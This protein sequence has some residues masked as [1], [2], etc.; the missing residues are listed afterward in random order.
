MNKV[1][2]QLFKKYKTA[3]SY[4]DAALPQLERDIFSTG[5]Y[6]TKARR[7]KALGQMLVREYGGKVPS[8]LNELL[9]LPGVG[10]KTAYL[11]LKKAF[12][13][14]VGI[15]VDT[16]VFRLAH[17]FGLSNAKTPDKMSDELM[18]LFDPK[19]YLDV[20]EF[21]ILHGRANPR[22]GREKK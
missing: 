5:F 9:R 4:A 7:L 11:V 3:K 10:R 21:L 12:G 19:D 1:T 8:S 20:N 22:L 16:H 15:A 6:K 18:R 17:A 13:K 2:P 14:N